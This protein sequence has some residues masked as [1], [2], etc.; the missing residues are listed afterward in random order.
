MDQNIPPASYKTQ[1]EYTQRKQELEVAF[2]NFHNIVKSKVLD[3]NK[4]PGL[5]KTEMFAINELVKAAQAL[6]NINVGEGLL[7]L[8]SIAV[9]EHLI[10]RDRINELEYEICQALKEIKKLKEKGPNSDGKKE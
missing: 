9:R 10:I 4:S 6:E 8:A 3:K 2:N 1:Q 7:A 5:K